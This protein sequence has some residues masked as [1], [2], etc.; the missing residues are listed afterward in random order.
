[1]P[2]IP[3]KRVIDELKKAFPRMQKY[4]DIADVLLIG[5]ILDAVNESNRTKKWKFVLKGVT[6]NAFYRAYKYN[7]LDKHKSK[8]IAFVMSM[9]GIRLKDR[10]D[11]YEALKKERI[12]LLKHL[13]SSSV[14]RNSVSSLLKLS[15]NSLSLIKQELEKGTSQDQLATYSKVVNYLTIEKKYNKNYDYYWMGFRFIADQ[16][17]L[18]GISRRILSKAIV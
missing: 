7:L 12:G 6:S 8:R 17:W 9:R 15:S 10:K 13:A 1:M 2:H 11:T 14:A 18:S 3:K 16:Y 5:R 4:D